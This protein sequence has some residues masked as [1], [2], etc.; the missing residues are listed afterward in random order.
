MM[1]KFHA[2]GVLVTTVNANKKY[3]LLGRC[4]KIKQ[5]GRRGYF[6]FFGGV[7]EKGEFA[8]ETAARE[9][10]EESSNT[11]TIYP[12]ELKEIGNG[13]N[14]ILYECNISY[15]DAMTALK[16]FHANEEV[17]KLVLTELGK[18]N[19]INDYQLSKFALEMLKISNV[20]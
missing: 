11:L 20:I 5:I 1:N 12:K 16:N 15:I 18:L 17:D 8:E 9:A 7:A 13:M 2:A 4:S 6:E 14:Y 19:T 3:V 10:K